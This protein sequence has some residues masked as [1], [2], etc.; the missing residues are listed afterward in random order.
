MRTGV[1]SFLYDIRTSILPIIFIFNPE[2][3]LIGVESVWHGMLVAFIALVAILCFA[4][5]TQ[6]WA[7]TRLNLVERLLLLLV[8]VAL[9]R[10]DYFM[11]RVYPEFAPVPFEELAAAEDA[12]RLLPADRAVRLHVERET[13]YGTRYK[14]FVIQ[15]ESRDAASGGFAEQVG[16]TAILEDDGRLY[17]S[18]LKFFGPA[19]QAGLTFGDFITDIDV[20]QFG[21]PA[22]EWVY[23]PGFLILAFVLAWQGLK[24][25]RASRGP[26]G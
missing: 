8:V 15:P 1:Q 26:H 18:N 9:F 4:S 12:G 10:P 7:V 6:G 24:V 2:I 22:K 13:E 14:L 3:L 17:V 23:L 16:V 11:N 5:V 19:E 20:E 21:R 25:R